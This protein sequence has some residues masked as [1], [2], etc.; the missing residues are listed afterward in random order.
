MYSSLNP[1]LT[2]SSK[3]KAKIHPRQ[4]Q[5]GASKITIILLRSSHYIKYRRLKM[6]IKSK[7]QSAKPKAVKVKG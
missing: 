7:E 6:W 5:I 4:L 3:D 2:K 1:V